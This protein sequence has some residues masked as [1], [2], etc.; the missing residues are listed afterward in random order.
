MT[1]QSI[2]VYRNPAEA[3]LWE[4]G[5]VFPLICG[6]V[7]GCILAYGAATFWDKQFSYGT[8][9][10]QYTGHIALVFA[11]IGVFGTMWWMAI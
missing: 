3:A 2:I 9:Y 7:I 8:C 4:S 5:M 6:M 11:L 1:T 10:R